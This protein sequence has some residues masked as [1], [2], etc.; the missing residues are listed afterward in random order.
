MTLENIHQEEN[1]FERSQDPK[2][3]A[4]LLLLRSEAQLKQKL[5]LQGW[6]LNMS[7]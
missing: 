6:Q 3:D 7:D 4:V 5:H 2:I 1:K